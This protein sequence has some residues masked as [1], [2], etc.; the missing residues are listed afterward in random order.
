MNAI[1]VDA[2][3]ID[4]VA[5]DG[6]AFFPSRSGVDLLFA[7]DDYW[8]T[9][10]MARVGTLPFL[11]LALSVTALWAWR[12]AGWQG[13][14]LAT[15]ALSLLPPVLAHGGVATLDMA[16]AATV[17][18]AL[19]AFAHFLGRPGLARA[20]LFGALSGLALLT[21]LSSLAFI[22]AGG[23]LMLGLQG[24]LA[25]LDR[26]QPRSP[27]EVTAGMW[28][29][30]LLG[31]GLSGLFIIWLGYGFEVSG[32]GPEMRPHNDVDR[33]VGSE[34]FAHDAAYWLVESVPIPM[35]DFLR[36]LQGLF[37]KGDKGH[38]TYFLGEA[39]WHGAP[40][41]FPV[42]LVMKLPLA[43]LGLV[44]IGGAYTVADTFARR[45]RSG[46][47]A[48]LALAG[49]LGI[50]LVG[51][52]AGVANGLRQVLAMM[53]LLAVV[54][55]YGAVRML[56]VEGRLRLPARVGLLGLFG[57]FAVSSAAAH[58]DY[59]AWFNPLAGDHPEEIAVDSDLDWG[60]D[61]AR[62]GPLLESLGAESVWIQYNG[63]LGTPLE[64]F[65]LPPF[66]KL[67]VNEPV[68]GWIAI[69]VLNLKLGTREPPYD[70]YAWLAEHEPVARAGASIWIYRVP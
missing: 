45:P 63:S 7:G 32:I 34:G 23:A 59:L 18:A 64:R 52:F 14:L 38:L 39:S 41:F 67:P 51:V 37:F 55:G 36:A 42:M 53:P 68:E 58:P 16:C 31:A 70:Q 48:A 57:W 54:A 22:V 30:W 60:Q 24:A 12:A 1:G 47:V 44:L 3:G 8:Q 62:L 40:L 56:R 26:D 27:P 6:R 69:S 50:L 2:L 35:P 49:A 9:L 4:H 13:A 65:G 19:L 21:K 28:V 10:A 66:E 11:V 46:S 15:F 43:F 25:W 17:A 29:R 5:Y 20:L 61:L 33:L